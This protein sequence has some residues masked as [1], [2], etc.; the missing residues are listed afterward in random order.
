MSREPEPFCRTPVKA[1]DFTTQD[2]FDWIDPDLPVGM[3]AGH[4]LL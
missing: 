2:A 1:Y 3:A 4:Q